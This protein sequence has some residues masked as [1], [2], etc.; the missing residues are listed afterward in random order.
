MEEEI[1]EQFIKESLNP[2]S[3]TCTEKILEQMRN[4]VCKILKGKIIGTGF[5]AK[6]P[7]NKS[8]LSVLITNNHVLDESDIIDGKNIVISVNNEAKIMDIKIHSKRK[9]YTNKDYDVTIIEIKEEE[10]NIKD[11]LLL[12]KTIINLFKE[13]NNNNIDYLSNIYENESIYLLNYMNGGE[14]FA[15]YGLLTNIEKSKITHK[16]NTDSGSSGSPILLLKNN[17]VIG[18]HYGFPKHNSHINFGTL[19]VKPLIEFQEIYRNEFEVNKEKIFDAHEEKYNQCFLRIRNELNYIQKHQISYFSVSKGHDML[20]WKVKING[21]DGSPYEG[22]KF[23]LNVD[24]P[25]D[26]PFYPFIPPKINFITK[27]Y[28]LNINP[29]I[30]IFRLSKLDVWTPAFTITDIVKEILNLMSKPDIYSNDRQIP[31]IE[32]IYHSNRTQYE[33]IAR[34]W[35]EKYA[36]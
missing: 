1:K 3:M 13:E 11:F 32:K 36:L 6:I 12:D 23:L 27:I 34:D 20:N 26:Y 30:G 16:C 9:K 22:G 25:K 35:T 19:L 8:L 2:V 14:I 15:S 5:F 18:I 31:E 4:N 24:F 29:D 21:P 7:F 17:Q 33:N 28:H 10:D